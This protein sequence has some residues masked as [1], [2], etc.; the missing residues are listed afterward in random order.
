MISLLAVALE[1]GWAFVGRDEE[2]L[3]VRPPYRQWSTSTVS[4]SIVER[5]IQ[6]HGFV[7]MKK[8]FTDWSSLVAFLK[9]QLVE[10]RKNQG[11]TLPDSAKIREL[12]QHAP[13]P[14]LEG[15][16]DRIQS[17]LLPHYEWR[18]SF[19]LL[20]TLIDLDIVKNNADL[21]QR[22]IDL[23]KRCQETEAKLQAGKQELIGEEQSLSEQFPKAVRAYSLAGVLKRSRGVRNRGQVM[24]VGAG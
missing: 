18:A 7:P 4:E 10:A 16:L 17:E 5:A 22:T 8:D 21:R 9:V 12:V 1:D 14:I 23:L 20:T 15:Y 13:K 19:D 2:V 3:L 24:P 11:D 6:I